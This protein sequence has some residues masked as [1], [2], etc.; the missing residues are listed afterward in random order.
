[1]RERM[2]AARDGGAAL[3]AFPELAISGYPAEDLL[4]RSSF[5]RA[6]AAEIDALA[7]EA[8]GIAAYVGHPHAQ[9]E[10]YNAASL[11]RDGEIEL[12]YR[13]QALPNY[14]VF[15]EKR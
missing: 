10:V 12:T 14:T 9:G 15:D 2:A 4:L 11:L 3:V 6:C 13:K 5:L 7:R 8:T 1:M